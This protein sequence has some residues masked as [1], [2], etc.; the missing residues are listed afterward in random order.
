MKVNVRE[1]E[2]ERLEAFSD[3]VFAFA[4]TLL[5]LNLYDPTMRGSSSLFQGLVDEWPAFFALATSFMTVLVMWIN[6]HNMFNYIKRLSREFMLLNGLLLLFV[7]ITPFTTLL[8]SE[9]LVSAD[10]NAAAAVYSG[11][12]FLIS[13]VWNVLWHN[14]YHH[15]HLISEHVP[16]SHIRLI[17]RQYYVGPVLYGVAMLLG[18][19]NA[20]A[21]VSLII[22]VAVYYAITVSGGEF[23]EDRLA[24]SKPRA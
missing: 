8:V 15:H 24:Q 13:V 22:L 4:I 6:H 3:G 9:H 10:A 17:S 21:A 19:V 20:V 7:V 1:R 18:F 11:S 16:S 23:V 12:F 5:V 14:A 2:T